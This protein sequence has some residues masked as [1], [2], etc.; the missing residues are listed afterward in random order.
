MTHGLGHA[1]YKTRGKLGPTFAKRKF[2]WFSF[3]CSSLRIRT[4]RL[5]LLTR[6]HVLRGWSRSSWLSGSLSRVPAVPVRAP[7]Q[8]CAENCSC[9]GGRRGAGNRNPE[10]M[11]LAPHSQ[12]PGPPGPTK[13]VDSYSYSS[14]TSTRRRPRTATAS[15]PSL[16]SCRPA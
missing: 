9:G 15:Q 7:A 10:G 1:M 5:A 6:W 2:T 12:S 13:A 11:V 3:L 14:T 16:L 8:L 4:K